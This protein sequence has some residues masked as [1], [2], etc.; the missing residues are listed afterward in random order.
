MDTT[1][2]SMQFKGKYILAAIDGTNS[3]EWIER[4]NKGK[5]FGSNSH[6]YQFYRDFM[7]N[8][9]RKDYWHGPGGLDSTKFII[10]WGIAAGMGSDQ[11]INEVVHFIKKSIHDLTGERLNKRFLSLTRQQKFLL[12]KKFENHIRI[13]LVGHSRGGYLCILV[14]QKLP[15]PVYFMGLYDA[16]DRHNT[17]DDLTTKKIINV[18]FPY[19][20]LRDPKVNSRSYFGNVGTDLLSPNKHFFYTTHGGI[21]G[22]LEEALDGKADIFSQC[23]TTTLQANIELY[24][25]FNR[26]E[27]CTLGSD[28]ADEWIRD[29]AKSL[30]LKF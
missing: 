19:H 15:L 3:R 16:V 9:G 30:G 8:G 29:K 5:P 4:G 13:C 28:L 22:D 17:P 12:R 26:K 24:L 18:D 11:I 27:K 2:F 1:G 7:T 25:K 20:A 10:D 14:A 6:T 21:G 23:N